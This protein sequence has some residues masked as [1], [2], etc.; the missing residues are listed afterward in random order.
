M[1]GLL[2]VY[3]ELDSLPLRE[4]LKLILHRGR[5]DAGAWQSPDKRVWLGATRMATTDLSQS[6]RLPLKNEDGNIWV[7][8]DGAV[9]NYNSMRRR[10]E[11]KGH[12]FASA[13]DSEVIVHAYEMWSEACL[14]Y[15]E[16]SFSFV[17]WDNKIKQLIVSRDRTG[18]KPIYYTEYEGGLFVSSEIGPLLRVLPEIPDPNP[19]AAAYMMTLGYIPSPHSIWRNIYK[20]EPGQM[21]GWSLKSG[22]RLRRYWEPPRILLKRNRPE[23][24]NE[25]LTEVVNRTLMADVPVNFLMP[26]GID[27]AA[28]AFALSDLGQTPETLTIT[29]LNGTGL[30]DNSA[31]TLAA[32]LDFPHNSESISAQRTEADL[33][34]ALSLFNEPCAHSQL[35]RM[36]EL[37]AHSARMGQLMI[38]YQGADPL[39]Y[40]SHWYHNRTRSGNFL[41]RFQRGLLGENRFLKSSPIAAHLW[42]IHNRFLPSEAAELIAP[43]RILFD[44]EIMQRP[45][46]RYYVDK[47]P[48]QRNLQRID[49][50]SY[51]ADCFFPM[52]SQA[53][54]VNSVELRLPFADR[55]MV[56][57]GLALLENRSESNVPKYFLQEY[58]NRTG[59]NIPKSNIVSDDE[60]FTELPLD[61]SLEQMLS[62][63][64][65]S[66]WVEEGYWAPEWRSIAERKTA[67]TQARIWNLYILSLWADIWFKE[68]PWLDSS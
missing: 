26:D 68:R 23:Q 3:S 6:G 50:M 4:A 52:V 30:G 59:K 41:S 47:L 38:S 39:F 60:G 33:R 20:L 53:A 27:G 46:M 24:L 42:G 66:Y 67:N 18:V 12:R 35:I 63:I 14:D 2:A 65:N 51:F 25:V 43:S 7:V 8:A 5:D 62:A 40:G 37:G 44:A 15:L 10:L 45:L 64:E 48:A 32:E 54:I 58:L 56:E 19:L 28:L 49:L 17:L 13:N 22:L 9:T 34:N 16:G 21:L 36:M 55:R 57:W 31:S 29:G 11:L 1:S 61:L